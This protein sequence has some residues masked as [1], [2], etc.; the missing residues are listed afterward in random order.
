MNAAEDQAFMARA[1][2]LAARGR[3]TTHPN[4][5]VG[6]VLVRDG[7]ILAEAWHERAG[8]LHAEAA[9]L[10]RLEESAAGATAYV[11]LEPCSHE[12]RTPPCAPA[13]VEAGVARVVVPALDPNPRVSGRGAAILRAAGIAVDI[14]PLA[15]EARA[16]NA[17]FFSR[18]E[19][20]RP[21]ILV[22]LAASLD[23]RTAMASGESR[24]ITAAEARADVHRLR[25]ECSAVLSGIGTVLADDPSLTV[26]LEDRE[27]GGRQP[28]RVVLD[29]SLRMPSS[30]RMLALPGDT[31]VFTAARASERRAVLESAGATVENV[32]AVRGGL[33][34]KAVATRL[35]E[36]ECNDVL[37]EAGPRLAGAWVSSGLA[38]GLVLY[39]APHLLGHEGRP[40]VEVP[41]L[42]RMS[43]RLQLR[44]RRLRQIGRDLRLDLDIG[45]N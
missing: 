20:G 42:E 45:G 11:T 41:G 10:A 4:P 22:K 32:P 35:G 40:L 17:G 24:W 21:R 1:L 2:R 36:L 43:E 33:D 34:L 6:C 25:A 31:L 44:V 14:G 3:C 38:D 9:A 37:V 7:R 23:G 5:R 13:L 28:L 39:L 19:T 30:A 16:L 27:S 26:R 18:M 15:A 12:G 8:G 29:S